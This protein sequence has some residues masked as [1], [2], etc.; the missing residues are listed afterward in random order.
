VQSNDPSSRFNWVAGAFY[1]DDTQVA[2]QDIQVNFLANASTVCWFFLPDFLH[3]TT[4]GPP[5][6]PGH[7][8][9]ENWF[10]VQMDPASDVWSINFRTRDRQLA[11]FVQGD[12]NITSRLKVTAGLRVSNNKLDFAAKYAS[13]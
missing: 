4:D 1:S 5:F 10:G 7:S 12:Y 9:F 3:A 8:A 11:C 6:G 2:M 13:P